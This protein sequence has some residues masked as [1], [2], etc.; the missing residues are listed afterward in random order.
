MPDCRW[1]KWCDE[2]YPKIFID[3]YV[4][5][6]SCPLTQEIRSILA[7][8][9]D[10]VTPDLSHAPPFGIGEPQTLGQGNTCHYVSMTQSLHLSQ[11]EGSLP[12]F[13]TVDN[14][15][16]GTGVRHHWQH[17][18]SGIKRVIQTFKYADGQLARSKVLENVYFMHEKKKITWCPLSP[19]SD[20]LPINK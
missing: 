1:L 3:I 12:L 8:G 6:G 13:S 18:T 15:L 11:T 16:P 5:K 9:R 17:S 20:R 10:P 7:H 2:S 19:L 14:N 4:I